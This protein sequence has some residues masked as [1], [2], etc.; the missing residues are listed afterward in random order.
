MGKVG[1]GAGGGVD[2]RKT[3]RIGEVRLSHLIKCS[4]LVLLT[5]YESL[6]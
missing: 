6:L 3:R 5:L 2:A 1:V 4:G